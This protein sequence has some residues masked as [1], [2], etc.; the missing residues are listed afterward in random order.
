MKTRF[1][2]LGKAKRF[3]V[4]PLVLLPITELEE[5]EGYLP[6]TPL[7]AFLESFMAVLRADRSAVFLTGLLPILKGKN[8]KRGATLLRFD[9]YM[10]TMTCRLFP[11]EAHSST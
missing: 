3:T 2:S 6:T 5:L 8:R 4:T 9:Q 7:S 1:K 10:E 11:A